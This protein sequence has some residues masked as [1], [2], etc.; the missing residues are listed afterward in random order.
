MKPQDCSF[1]L[2]ALGSGAGGRLLPKL[3]LCPY[4]VDMQA[5]RLLYST[6]DSRSPPSEPSERSLQDLSSQTPAVGSGSG[7]GWGWSGEGAT[8]STALTELARTRTLRSTQEP[9]IVSGHTLHRTSPARRNANLK[10]TK[11]LEAES[12]NRAS[13]IYTSQIL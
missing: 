13:K 12:Y 9:A 5:A 8:C 3:R 10:N 7:V 4:P 2:G 11:S 6:W 1:A